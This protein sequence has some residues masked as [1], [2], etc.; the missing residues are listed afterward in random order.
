MAAPSKMKKH[1]AEE[2]GMPNLTTMMD[3]MTIILLFLLKTMSVSGQLLHQAPGIEL[4][5]SAQEVEPERHLMFIMNSQGI[6]LEEEGQIGAQ[7]ATTQDLEDPEI[8][9][10]DGVVGYLDSI[11]QEDRVLGRKLRSIVTLQGDREIPYKYLYK[12]ITSAAE[13]EFQTVQF[14]VE[15]E[16][17]GGA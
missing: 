14:V 3:M 11:R 12:F 13:S 16:Y 6:F 1:R 5:E 7:V 2:A 8:V 4:P 9:I 17:E 10:F 15:K